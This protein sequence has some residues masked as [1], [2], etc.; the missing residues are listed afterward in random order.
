MAKHNAIRI[1]KPGI[2]SLIQDLGRHGYQH[3][4]IT[5]GGPADIHA[6]CWANKL[7]GNPSNAACMEL[8]LGLQQ[9]EV[10]ADNEIAICGANFT[11]TI[12]DHSLANWQRHQV[13]KGDVI[14]FSAT[15]NGRCGYFA[16][17]GGFNCHSVLGSQSIVMRDKLDQASS[18]PLQTGQVIASNDTVGNNTKLKIKQTAPLMPRHY[19]PNYQ[20]DLV[21]KLMPCYQWQMLTTSQQRQFLTNDYQVALA[22]NRMGFKLTG[23]PMTDLPQQL[24]SEGIAMGSVQLPADGQPIVLLNDRQSIG[25]YPKAGVIS[26][27]DCGQLF[28]RQTGTKIR[29][30]MANS[31]IITQKIRAFIR[32]FDL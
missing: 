4:G 21:L 6:F 13:Y 17:A 25:G 1:L 22:S 10:L 19:I 3:L 29:F 16:I 30:E 18:Q 7:L 23:Q 12:N 31:E 9:F 20:H 32:Y 2:L 5:V 27:L 26:V 28:Q 24:V 15:N 8:H 14:T 11:A